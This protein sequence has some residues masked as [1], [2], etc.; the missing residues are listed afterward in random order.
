MTNTGVSYLERHR[1]SELQHRSK[2]QQQAVPLPTQATQAPD[3]T[4][5]R[6][7]GGINHYHTKIFWYRKGIQHIFRD[8]DK[9]SHALIWVNYKDDHSGQAARLPIS[10][11]KEPA[12]HDPIP[13]TETLPVKYDSSDS[14]EPCSPRKPHHS[15]KVTTDTA[16]SLRQA[17]TQ[18][19]LSLL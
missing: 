1:S 9:C 3:E 8:D 5:Q 16:L 18:L 17:V 15:K 12:E 14:P 19:L 2:R 10:K 4:H 6:N 11:T 13:Y 7:D